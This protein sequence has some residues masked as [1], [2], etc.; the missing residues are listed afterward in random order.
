M[1]G[2][3]GDREAQRCIEQAQQEGAI[4]L[5]LSGLKLT[6]VPEDLASL[7]QLQRLGLHNNQLTEVPEDLASLT[8]LQWLILSD[9]QLRELPEAIGALTQ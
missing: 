5:D 4:T 7:T 9:D 8:Q 1:L 6:E 3:E 2:N